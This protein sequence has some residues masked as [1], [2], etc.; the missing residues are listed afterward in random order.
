MSLRQRTCLQTSLRGMWPEHVSKGHKQAVPA[1]DLGLGVEEA[2]MGC[3]ANR[4]E[5]NDWEYAQQNIY[6]TIFFLETYIDVCAFIHKEIH[7]K[8][9]SEMSM[10]SQL[11]QESGIVNDFYFLF[12][13]CMYCLI[14]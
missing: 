2:V 14:L 3:G 7:E 11:S 4:G 9:V 5:T 13:I 12:H 6:D 8:T 1:A 10:G